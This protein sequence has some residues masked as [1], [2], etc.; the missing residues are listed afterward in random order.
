MKQPGRPR[1]NGVQPVY[2][3]HRAMVGLHGYDKMRS[4]GEKYQEALKGGVEEVRREIPEVPISITE[5]K[6]ALAEF[7]SED[8]ELTFLVT[9]SENTTAIDGTKFRKAWEIRI[10]PNPDYPRH[11][12]HVDPHATA[13]HDEVV[14]AKKL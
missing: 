13:E 11:N 2:A 3:F 8:M 12:A 4:S 6:R 10:G 7:R 5:I 14:P 9:P 1:K